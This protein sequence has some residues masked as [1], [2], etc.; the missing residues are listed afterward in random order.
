MALV[1][2]VEKH[3]TNARWTRSEIALFIGCLLV[4]SLVRYPELGHH[5]SSDELWILAGANGRAEERFIEWDAG[6]WIPVAKSP[7]N[8]ENSRSFSCIW[9][10]GVAM[11]PP[12]YSISL[13]VWRELFGGSRWIASS[14]GALCSLVGIAFVFSALRIQAGARLATAVCLILSLSIV[15][16]HLATDIRGYA[17]LSML[18][19][20][21]AWQMVRIE[22]FGGGV[23]K[24]WCLGL[25]TLLMMMTHYFS[26]GIC[27]ALCVWAWFQLKGKLRVHF[28]LAVVISAGIFLVTW[29]PILLGQIKFAESTKGLAGFL[30]R[31]LPVWKSVFPMAMDLPIRIFGYPANR[32]VTV[33]MGA[34][35]FFVVV[36]G[37]RRV[38]SVRIWGLL[39]LLGIG[40]VLLIDL[41]RET[42]HVAFMRYGSLVSVAVPSA[43]MLAVHGMWGKWIWPMVGAVL[44]CLVLQV[45]EPRDVGSV[46]FHHA[47]SQLTPILSE[48]P[49]HYPLAACTIGRSWTGS[50]AGAAMVEFS[51]LPGFLP[52]ASMID[53]EEWS[54][55]PGRSRDTAGRFWL[56]TLGRLRT[57]TKE[58]IVRELPVA[59]RRKF[60][61]VVA[62]KGPWKIA[63]SGWGISPRPAAK[64]WLLEVPRREASNPSDLDSEN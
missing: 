42:Q 16:A 9:T 5:F 35:L 44:V 8:L 18:I 1:V 53:L 4:A 34:L 52:R 28:F 31:D 57:L 63:A 2:A 49:S 64:L 54:K 20:C 24:S 40:A 3:Y 25:M 38:P 51:C 6:V 56:M 27:F 41:A 48:Y 26:V 39:Y 62:V 61:K 55:K 59:I 36:I 10:E 14:Y 15:Q 58:N 23:A 17:L 11:H 32:M 33:A 30:D 22:A 60:P 45:K 19:A 21:A 37:M 13:R 29:G 46:H 12:L 43:A 50:Q 47:T 7:I